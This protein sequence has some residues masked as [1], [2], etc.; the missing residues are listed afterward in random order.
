MPVDFAS[1]G[2]PNFKRDSS[3]VIPITIQIYTHETSPS[4]CTILINLYQWRAFEIA[5]WIIAIANCTRHECI[6][7]LLLNWIESHCRQFHEI[8]TESL[9]SNICNNSLLRAPVP[10]RSSFEHVLHIIQ[11]SFSL[12]FRVHIVLVPRYHHRWPR[13]RSVQNISISII[14]LNTTTHR[15]CTG[16]STLRRD[17]RIYFAI[18]TMAVVHLSI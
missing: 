9:H 14:N 10:L 3:D 16:L 12:T 8:E 2:Y 1:L 18:S 11:P 4:P 15:S 7:V 13:T 17:D 5:D 6:G